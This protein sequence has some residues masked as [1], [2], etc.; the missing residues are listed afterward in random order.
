MTGT[1]IQQLKFHLLRRGK[2]LS[3]HPAFD[4]F[5][6]LIDHPDLWHMTQHSVSG[7]VAL[8][9][10]AAMLPIPFQ[11]LVGFV[12]ALALRVNIALTMAMIFITNPLTMGPI[13][14]AAYELGSW[15]LG[16]PPAFSTPPTNYEAVV[17][18]LTLVWKPL[19]VG[20]LVAGACASLVGYLVVRLSWSYLSGQRKG[21]E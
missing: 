19:L 15:L 2:R 8:G 20:S 7:A 1:R 9:L 3:R 18:I 11:M 5:R 17:N 16:T 10:F 21:G 13:F 12:L 14:Y 6:H 4:R